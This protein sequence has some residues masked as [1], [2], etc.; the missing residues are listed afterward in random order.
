MDIDADGNHESIIHEDQK[1][2]IYKKIVLKDNKVIGTIL[3]G[4][5]KGNL[6]LLKAIDAGT[7]VGPIMDKL[8]EWDLSGL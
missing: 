4:D 6:K 2:H 3:Y 1:N 5:V 8:K 7:D